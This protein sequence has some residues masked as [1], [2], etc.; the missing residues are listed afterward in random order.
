MHAHAADPLQAYGDLFKSAP[1]PPLMRQGI[2]EPHILKHYLLLHDDAAAP[3]G[4]ARSACNICTIFWL[5]CSCQVIM[6][7]ICT[8]EVQSLAYKGV[9]WL[10]V[11]CF[12]LVNAQH[13]QVYR[14]DICLA[15]LPQ[16]CYVRAA[17]IL[18]ICEFPG[19]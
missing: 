10:V 9:C 5:N 1:L 11:E 15:K 4:F 12:G 13:H 16:C 17:N 7:S 8:L 19:D 14:S 18:M 3:G 2:M 6:S